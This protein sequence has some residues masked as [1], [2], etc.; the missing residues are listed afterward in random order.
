MLSKHWCPK[1]KSAFLSIQEHEAA[2]GVT[3]FDCDA[4]HISGT[5]DNFK[6]R[7]QIF[8]V[9]GAAENLLSKHEDD[10]STGTSHDI[11]QATHL[12]RTEVISPTFSITQRIK[13]IRMS[14][15]H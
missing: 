12:A 2:G 14:T 8:L 6:A 5:K 3:V 13:N 10:I 7:L 4:Q 1:A 11:Q 9:D 15:T